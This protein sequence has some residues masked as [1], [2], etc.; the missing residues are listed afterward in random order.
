MTMSNLTATCR[1]C[2]WTI[3]IDMSFK[4][5]ISPHINWHKRHITSSGKP[6]NN[7]VGVCKFEY[8]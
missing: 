4:D 7:I 3:P 6:I 5:R 8:K 2:G 1:L